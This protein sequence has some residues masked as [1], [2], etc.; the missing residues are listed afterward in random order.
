[1]QLHEQKKKWWPHNQNS[2]C[3]SF[4]YINDGAKVDNKVPKLM[5]CHVCY[6]NQI[7]I[8]NSK[9]KLRKRI[10]SYFENNGI[11]SF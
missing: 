2:L 8:T 4:Y 10:I 11:T 9:T 3:W 7:T 1:M 6:P 5:R